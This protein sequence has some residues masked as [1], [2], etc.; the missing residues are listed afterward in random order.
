MTNR[1]TAMFFFFIFER[2]AIHISYIF[3][4]IQTSWN[5]ECTCLTHLG[6]GFRRAGWE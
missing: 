3:V 4:L 2:D 1:G 5:E 6:D